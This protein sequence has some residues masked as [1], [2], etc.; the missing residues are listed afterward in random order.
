MPKVID[1]LNESESPPD[2]R[3][4]IA[5]MEVKI[6]RHYQNV[7]VVVT[8]RGSEEQRFS[9]R[10]NNDLDYERFCVPNSIKGIEITNEG[11][12][13]MMQRY[14]DLYE[15]TFNGSADVF[16]YN[17]FG[18]P[19]LLR[20]FCEINRGRTL[21]FS[22]IR[23][24]RDIFQMW[25]DSVQEK[26][27]GARYGRA[28]ILP[29]EYRSV[30]AAFSRLLWESGRRRVSG[31]DL[32][33][34]SHT[35]NNDWCSQW[36]HILVDEGLALGFHD[37]D[38]S[39]YLIEALHDQLGGYLI[40]EHLW[41]PMGHDVSIFQEV[42]D[43]EHD[44]EYDILQFI[45]PKWMQMNQEND[46]VSAVG[47]KVNVLFP[48]IMQTMRTECNAVTRNKMWE[49]VR[50]SPE[51]VR[52]YFNHVM[53]N[54]TN[55]RK[56]FNGE[57]LDEVLSKM[58][59]VERDSV[60]GVWICNERSDIHKRLDHI[61][62]GHRLYDIDDFC[63]IFYWCKWLLVSNIPKIRDLATHV[64]CALGEMYP[65]KAL[66]LL[67]TSLS[68]NDLFVLE[69][70]VAAGYGICIFLANSRYQSITSDEL[71]AY[72]NRLKA[73]LFAKKSMQATSHY[74]VLSYAVNTIALLT[75][76]QKAE[77]KI[78]AD[79]FDSLARITEHDLGL[80]SFAT[81]GDNQF[82]NKDIPHMLGGG[83]YA[84]NTPEYRRTYPLIEK[85]IYD[86]GYRNTIFEI[87]K[88][89]W[90]GNY[91]NRYND[92]YMYRFGKKYALIAYM[93]MKGCL[94]R[95]IHAWDRWHEINIDPTFPGPP[96]VFP[97]SE[98]IEIINKFT[99]MRDWVWNGYCPD[100]G[101]LS[102]G[103]F[104]SDANDEWILVDGYIVEEPTDGR[105]LFI[106]LHGFLSSENDVNELLEKYYAFNV[107]ARQFHYSFHGESPWSLNWR[108]PCYEP[109]WGY[110]LKLRPEMND[111]APYRE[112]DGKQISMELLVVN[113]CW[114]HYHSEENQE[115]GTLLGSYFANKMNLRIVPHRWEYVDR[116]G[117]VA[118]RF[119]RTKTDSTRMDLFYIRRD[120]LER[121]ARIRRKVFRIGYWG[122]RQVQ[123]TVRE[124][125]HSVFEGFKDYDNAFKGMLAPL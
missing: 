68:V 42:L 6:K 105:R 41:R 29:S 1:G 87:D 46:I 36:G 38:S 59:M 117:K 44:L 91:S 93:E 54:A 97:A 7:K 55:G 39:E 10:R 14:F 122:E 69:R 23:N 70:L 111:S 18:S 27:C 62:H 24:C 58:T 15:I 94:D 31:F 33:K 72:A 51:E 74:G 13:P 109:E 56:S 73:V 28:Y 61:F 50:S 79:P 102:K 20:V 115:N 88:D 22:D 118:A 34:A 16:K 63:S 67:A 110:D 71:N 64:I 113:Y 89:I 108:A 19:L 78:V 43:K 11:L 9:H 37:N 92:L 83:D 52:E 65:K 81:M 48:H 96:D 103:T 53:W 12:P 119:C 77:M 106:D 82:V 8:Y 76:N 116:K 49:Y 60:W 66:E 107:G 80:S 47:D 112:N 85:R 90:G 25:L 123:Y 98:S 17:Y 21:T 57:A 3:D 120:V 5:L 75:R 114:E 95:Q 26:I 104:F 30:L 2:W 32:D 84:T 40:S 124:K 125:Y 100:V 99:N 45:V 121:Y 86:L 35:E 4:I 101:K